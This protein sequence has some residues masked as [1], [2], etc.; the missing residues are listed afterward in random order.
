M[1]RH[2]WALIQTAHFLPCGRVRRV[3]HGATK[4]PQE[5]LEQTNRRGVESSFTLHPSTPPTGQP[6]HPPSRPVPAKPSSLLHPLRGKEATDG[7]PWPHTDGFFSVLEARA[8][9]A[10]WAAWGWES[11]PYHSPIWAGVLNLEDLS[12]EALHVK[13]EG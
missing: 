4:I 6:K 13:V 12:L 8:A 5:L 2:H 11:S 1:E 3:M 9:R 7:S 10:A